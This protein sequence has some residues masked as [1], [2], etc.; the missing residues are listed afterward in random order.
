MTPRPRRSTCSRC[1]ARGRPT[2]NRPR[3]TGA[4]GP[5]PRP[6][7]RRRWT[8]VNHSVASGLARATVETRADLVLLGWEAGRSL[9]GRMFGSIIDQVRD[10]T[11]DPVLVSRL[12]RPINTVTRVR[13]VLPPAVG[14]HE[15]FSESIYL[16]KRLAEN[17]GVPLRAVAVGSHLP[18]ERYERLI[19]QV[20]PEMAVTV[21]AVDGLGADGADLGGDSSYGG[22]S[23]PPASGCGR[24][25]TAGSA[26]S[27]PGVR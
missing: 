20:D 18:P 25:S 3:P 5:R 24:R 19:G 4:C 14:Y 11:T 26:R 9:G 13:L 6:V 27:E 23:T 21:S 12:G 16:V 15:G 22:G 10:R 2:R 1:W 7:A 8:R 17:L